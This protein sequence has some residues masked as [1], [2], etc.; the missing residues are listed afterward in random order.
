MAA[1]AMEVVKSGELK[2][3]PEQYKKTWYHWMG[4]IRD[5]CISR[6][7]W[8]GHRIPA[9][10]VSLKNN[11]LPSNISD[12][13]RW[14]SARSETEAAEKAAKKFNVPVDNISLKQDPDVLDTWFSSGLFPFSV[15]GWPDQVRITFKSLEI[16][17]NRIN[18]FIIFCG[19]TDGRTEGFLS[20][21]LVGNRPRYS[22]L[23]G[24]QNG[25]L[26]S[27]VARQTAIQVIDYYSQISKE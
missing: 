18:D 19:I 23:L 7:L 2:I 12:D 1:N 21:R 5:W 14:V 9:Y 25:F 8:W 4:G 24:S 10:F 26:R 11:S 16:K 20:R 13:D 6:Q 17:R 15:F 27:K 22:V 3:V